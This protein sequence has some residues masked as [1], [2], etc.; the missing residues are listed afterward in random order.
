MSM[1]STKRITKSD[2]KSLGY[3]IEES[4]DAT[5]FPDRSA[6]IF[7]RYLDTETNERKSV[8]IGSFGI[9]HPL[10]L[11][12]FELGN[13]TTALEFNLEPFV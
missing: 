11:Q 1:L 10:V 4:E 8:Q 3:W 7:L 12:N 9:L 6:Y 5:Y 2:T 13:P